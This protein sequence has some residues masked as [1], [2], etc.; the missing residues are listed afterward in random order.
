MPAP[1]TRLSCALCSYA[2]MGFLGINTPQEYGG[3]GMGHL[4]ALIVLEEFGKVSSAVAFPIFEC[5]VGPIKAVQRFGSDEMRSRLLPPVTAGDFVVACAR[6]VLLPSP[7]PPPSHSTPAFCRVAM[8]E[9]DAGSAATDMTTAATADPDVEGGLILQ[10]QKR[11]CSGAGHSDMIVFCKM[12]P[13]ALGAKGLGAVYVKRDAPGVSFGEQETLMGPHPTPFTFSGAGS[14][15]A[16]LW[17]VGR[18]P[19]RAVGGHLLRA[20]EDRAD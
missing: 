8:S 7:P 13:S 10:G 2:E 1:L 3:L 20:G 19:R 16:E 14:S 12:D 4:D 15:P 17:G 11:W 5:L 6:R 18:V 9:P